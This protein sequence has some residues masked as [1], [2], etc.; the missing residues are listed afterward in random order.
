M[1]T[2]SGAPRVPGTGQRDLDLG[3]TARAPRRGRQRRTERRPSLQVGQT[4]EKDLDEEDDEDEG[5]ELFEEELGGPA[6]ERHLRRPPGR[7]ER[8]RWNTA[9]GCPS[10]IDQD[11]VRDDRSGPPAGRRPRSRRPERRA[12]DRAHPPREHGPS[13]GAAPRRPGRPETARAGRLR[14]QR[15]PSSRSAEVSS[16]VTA[17]QPPKEILRRVAVAAAFDP[18]ADILVVDALPDYGDPELPR[19]CRR[20]TRAA[21]RSRRRCDPHRAAISLS[22]PSWGCSSRRG[23]RRRGRVARVGPRPARSCASSPRANKR[24]TGPPAQARSNAKPRTTSPSTREY[25]ALMSVVV[26]DRRGKSR[27][28]DSGRTKRSPSGSLSRRRRQRRSWSSC[29]SGGTRL[30]RSPRPLSLP[31]G[32][33]RRNASTRAGGSPA[34]G[35]P[36][37]RRSSKSMPACAPR[38]AGGQLRGSN[39]QADDGPLALAAATDSLSEPVGPSRSERFRVDAP[40]LPTLASA[41]VYAPGP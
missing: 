26:A 20:A 19:R 36:A 39:V 18:T 31:D 1:K 7:G 33:V 38:S 32:S 15:A 13:G 24:A 30:T 27:A 35:V 5:D 25:S 6:R 11:P 4:Y 12:G 40:E 21:T 8:D 22:S 34:R 16:E 3:A 29:E 10:T 14:P 41:R 23:A 17:A 9:V 2:Y 37:R 28:T